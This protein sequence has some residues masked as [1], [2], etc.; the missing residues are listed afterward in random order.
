MLEGHKNRT[1]CSNWRESNF[2]NLFEVISLTSS[3]AIGVEM[4]D[5]GTKIGKPN[6][7]RMVIDLFRN[8]VM[9]I[10]VQIQHL[11]IYCKVLLCCSVDFCGYH[12][13]VTN[14]K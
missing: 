3:S 7:G 1:F 8:I 10:V 4:T 13:T 2:L 6:D 5:S 12:M 11:F 9:N 14:L